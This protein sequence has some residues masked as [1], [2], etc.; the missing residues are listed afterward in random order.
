MSCHQSDDPKSKTRLAGSEQA[1]DARDI[2]LMINGNKTAG[3]TS[4][5]D[6]LFLQSCNQVADDGMV[7]CTVTIARQTEISQEWSSSFVQTSCCAS[8]HGASCTRI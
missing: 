3:L 2:L 5:S 6:A 8:I 1:I 4:M 7:H